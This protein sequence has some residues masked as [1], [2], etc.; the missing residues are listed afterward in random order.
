MIE[1]IELKAAKVGFE[2]VI[3]ILYIDKKGAFTRENVSAISGAFRQFDTQH[4]N[5]FKGFKGTRVSPSR[6]FFKGSALLRRKKT[7]YANYVKRSG[8]LGTVMGPL[9]EFVRSFYADE[10]VPLPVL[11]AEELATLFHPPITE[12]VSAQGL[13]SVEV[14]KGGPPPNLPISP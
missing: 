13:R 14:V 3:R 11:N 5:A 7:M 2:T 8:K 10:K 9:Q 1:E 4:L 12:I 6:W